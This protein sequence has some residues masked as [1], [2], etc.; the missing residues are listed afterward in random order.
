MGL[1]TDR[2]PPLSDA[3]T[4][5]GWPI[6]MARSGGRV[7]NK[8]KR[9]AFAELQGDQLYEADKRVDGQFAVGDFGL[10]LGSQAVLRGL[11]VVHQVG[12]QLQRRRSPGALAQEVIQILEN[13]LGYDNTV[14]LLIDRS[15]RQL[16]P[17]A[18]SETA[19]G[20]DFSRAYEEYVETHD[21]RMGVGAAG[22]VAHHGRPLLYGDV[23]REAR[24]ESVRNEIRSVLFVP[25]RVEGVVIGT[26]GVESKL[27]DAFTPLDQQLLETVAGQIAIAI[28]NAH[29]FS[30]VRLGE[31]ESMTT[32][33]TR[34]LEAVEKTTAESLEPGEKETAVAETAVLTPV[35]DTGVDGDLHGAVAELRA[36]IE[37]LDAFNHTV[38]H[39][40]KNPLSI[41]LGFAEVLAHDYVPSDDEI[42]DQAIRVI[43]ENGRRMEI[44]INELLLL[45]E[46]RTVEQIPLEA[47][48]MAFVISETCNRLDN[49]VKE[50]QAEVQLPESWPRAMGHQPWV[51]EIWV[52]YLSNAIKYGGPSPT[53]TLG[54][55]I[56]D[57]TMAR[58]WIRDYGEGIV[59]VDQQ[60]LF[61]PFTKLQQ[62]N[63]Q[64]HGLGLS[65]VQRIAKKLG[66]DVGV[67]SKPGEGSL[68]WFTL[69]LATWLR[70]KD[71][72][73]R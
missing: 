46:V 7:N 48:D 18:L 52:N 68:F 8:E 41:L 53:V 21:M 60:R 20:K 26:I 35:L 62:A 12:L 15:A 37:E 11:D 44:I 73:I 56:H 16:K 72:I 10:G 47:L 33:N 2:L 54:G 66:G 69:P 70:D 19:F 64:G 50:H 57:E 58:F 3:A 30:R 1:T 22:W 29:L 25:I 55:E 34:Q 40:L 14:I 27:V 28:Q 39:D 31:M 65:I 5:E 24:F 4:E 42:L 36:Q 38:A 63:T 17:F 71:R 51:E 32:Q 9:V 23:H 59:P 43:I 61:I 67:E 6:N 49:L 13:T 45:A